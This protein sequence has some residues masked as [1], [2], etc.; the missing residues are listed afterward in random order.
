MLFADRTR[1]ESF[2]TVAELYD[3]ARPSYPPELIDALLAAAPR[4]VLDVGCGTG[5]AS[6]L[7]A[8]RGASVL[9]VEVDERMAS[10]ARAKGLEVEVATFEAWDPAGRRFDLVAAAQAWHWI[11]PAVGVAKAAELLDD[12]GAA[13]VF[14]NLGDPPPELAARLR[15]IY[16]RLEPELERDATSLG[17]AHPS[18]DAADA[19]L[20]QSG[21]FER[22]RILRF[23]WQRRYDTAG[24]LDHLQTHSDH[25]TLPPER[26]ERLLAAVAEAVEEIG[27]VFEMPYETVLVLAAR[28]VGLR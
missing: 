8:E 10:V 25:Q 24:W 23:A 6:A 11:D 19:S 28:K 16:A 7:L 12:G 17:N 22:P 18:V 21:A 1:A 4:R 15:P 3:R 26:L 27:G 20:R 2:G 5:I 14:W 9:G 13:A